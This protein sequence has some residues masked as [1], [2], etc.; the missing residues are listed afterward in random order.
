MG[1]LFDAIG[2][3]I[4]DLIGS[5]WDAVT[6]FLSVVGEFVLDK[7]IEPIMSFLGFTD[8]DIYLTD[9]IAVKVFDEDLFEKT[10][11]ELSLDYMKN[12]NSALQYITNFSDTG[13]KQFGKYYRHG[14]WDYLDYLPSAQINAVSI[15]TDNVKQ[16]LESINNSKVSINDIVTMVPYAED[17]CKYQLQELYNYNINEDYVIIN[18]I[19]YKYNR[20]Y[21]NSDN[22]TYTIVLSTIGDIINRLYRR[23]IVTI[24]SNDDTTDIKHTII[25]EQTISLRS[26]TGSIINDTGFIQISS[27]DEIVDKGSVIAS[28]NIKLILEEHIT[29]TV[30]YKNIS[31]PNH[32]NERRY[33]VK[34][35]VINTGKLKY[36]IYDPETNVYPN[37]TTPVQKIIGFDMYPIVMIRNSFFNVGD[38]D[39]SEVNGISRP[40]TITKERYDN[41]QLMLS[42]IGVSLEDLTKSYSENPDIDKIQDA[43]FMLGV[44]PSDNHPIV[45]KTL[46]EMFD[47]I[48][49]RI[50]YVSGTST[51]SASFKEDPYNAAIAWI[52]EYTT[53]TDEVIGSIGDYTH[54][55]R[56]VVTT[57][58]EYTIQ[59][60]SLYDSNNKYKKKIETYTLTELSSTYG[61]TLTETSNYSTK[62]IIDYDN[63]YEIGTT[64]TLNN[65]S[66]ENAKDLILKKQITNT[67]VKTI[68]IRNFTS[69]NIIR[70]GVSNGGVS[71]EADDENLVIPLPVPV[72]ERLTLLDRTA[73]LGRSVHLLFYAFEHQHLEWYE[74]EKF[75]KFL[76]FLTIAITVVV[77]I[78]SWGTATNAAMTLSSILL[79][80]LKTVTIG[81]ALQVALKM[82][83]TYVDSTFLKMALSVVAMI[84][85]IYIGSGFDNLNALTAIQLS[86][87]PVKAFDIYTN[88]LTSILQQD[89]TNFT[90][91]YSSM[92]EEYSNIIK[93]LNSGLTASDITELT[94]SST[95]DWF[96]NTGVSLSPSQFIDTAINSY[97]NYNLLY[98]GLY[99]SSVHDFVSNKLTLGI[100]GD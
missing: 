93:E 9:V 54:T 1:D 67:T 17:W 99:D 78:V 56:N 52:P 49:D 41:T 21:Y 36:W 32:N 30:T 72:V 48:Y 96:S 94:L 89:I 70:R 75:G 42:S 92:S 77:T 8:E 79:G 68:T 45:S 87:I 35:I 98:S 23:T 22:N 53:I 65:S 40:P 20:N 51:Y 15:D 29:N 43:F 63:K 61:S 14:K 62:I 31:I 37:L 47:F 85:A 46:F 11:I 26:D 44:S 27:N 33:V 73:L 100:I 13:D 34:Y 2:D 58:N 19:Y 7:I 6:D 18:N 80:T 64:K 59:T 81:V 95:N 88:D 57:V 84:I 55:I 12:D 39:K 38:Y 69:F 86:E 16:I 4:G 71:L 24:S 25:E 60:V 82:I 74:T 28:S 10:Q 76:Q 90:N 5:V 97:K 66:N 3:F 83:T 50:P 91:E